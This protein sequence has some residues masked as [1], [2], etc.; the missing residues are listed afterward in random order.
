MSINPPQ[1]VQL[2][3]AVTAQVEE[4]LTTEALAFVADLQIIVRWVPRAPSLN[5][6]EAQWHLA[7]GGAPKGA[8]Q[9][10]ALKH[11]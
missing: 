3:G 2:L 7:G 6:R 4:V 9:Y 11:V 8:S 1:G 10:R 5:M